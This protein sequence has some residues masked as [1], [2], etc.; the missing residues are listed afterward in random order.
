MS[1]SLLERHLGWRYEGFFSCYYEKQTQLIY[2]SPLYFV[3]DY[4][5]HRIIDSFRLSVLNS[6]ATKVAVV[7]TNYL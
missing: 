2:L 6:Q 3:T 4:H 7:V 1:A 5:A